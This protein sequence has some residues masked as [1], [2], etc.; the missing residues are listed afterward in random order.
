GW[1]LAREIKKLNSE[2]KVVLVTGWDVNLSSER[3]SVEKVV[4]EVVVKPFDIE[5][6]ADVIKK[7]F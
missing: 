6:I 2:V 1:D 3:G 4:D 5:K 7:L